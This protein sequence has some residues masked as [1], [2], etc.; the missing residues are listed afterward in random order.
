MFLLFEVRSWM[1]SALAK[2][3][4]AGQKV[5][6]DGNSSQFPP[7]AG[8]RTGEKNDTQASYGAA[9]LDIKGYIFEFDQLM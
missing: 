1:L 9:K 3:Q 4:T 6:T 2:D 8:C 7:S 5:S